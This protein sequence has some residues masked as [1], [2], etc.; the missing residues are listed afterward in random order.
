MLDHNYVDLFDMLETISLMD[1]YELYH[2]DVDLFDMLETIS[3][4]D[5][6]EFE[7]MDIF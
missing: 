1:N 5:N 3:L 4:M 7:I 2:N 6:Y